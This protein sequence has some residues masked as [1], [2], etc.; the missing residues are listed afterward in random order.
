MFNWCCGR[1]LNLAVSEVILPIPNDVKHREDYLNCK[2][3]TMPRV[4]ICE[5]W[6]MWLALLLI[7]YLFNKIL[8]QCS[9][10]ARHC[11]VYFTNNVPCMPKLL[12][13]NMILKLPISF[14]LKAWWQQQHKPSQQ[15]CCTVHKRKQISIDSTCCHLEK[16]PLSWYSY[17]FIAL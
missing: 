17:I 3:S 16:N 5:F 1:T 11:S 8:I 6:Q 13:K 2:W 14:H 7:P 4:F 9:P 12:F 15:L 10:C